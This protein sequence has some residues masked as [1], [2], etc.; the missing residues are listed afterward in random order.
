MCALGTNLTQGLRISE[1]FKCMMT[2]TESKTK[3]VSSGGIG[4]GRGKRKRVEAGKKVIES[5]RGTLGRRKPRRLFAL[6]YRAPHSP[7]FYYF[8]LAPHP[9]FSRRLPTEGTSSVESLNHEWLG[10][11]I[12]SLHII[13]LA[14]LH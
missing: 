1:Y 4:S 14:Y 6:P 9:Q 13:F 5:S 8:F 2:S 3:K 12:L 10:C 11:F 7:I